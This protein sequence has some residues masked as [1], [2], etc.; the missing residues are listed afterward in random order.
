MQIRKSPQA[1]AFFKKCCTET[2][3][4]FMEL[5]KWIRTRWASLFKMLERMLRLRKV[6]SFFVY[7]MH[8]S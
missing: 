8:V 1:R 3:V 5:L 7:I 6:L 2:G 4:T